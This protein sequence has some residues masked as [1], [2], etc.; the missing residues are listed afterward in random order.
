VH[1]LL[2]LALL[3]SSS[4]LAAEQVKPPPPE[5]REIPI[6][7][8]DPTPT[9]LIVAW[10]PAVFSLRVDTGKGGQFGSD[11]FEPLRGLARY[12]FQLAENKPYFGRVEVEGGRFETDDQSGLG[13]SGA[14]VTARLLAGAATRI[15]SGVIVIASAGLLTRYQWGRAQGGAPT[16]G[17]W[18]VV[19]NIELDVRVFP[20]VTLSAFVEGAIAPFPYV[21]QSNLGDLSDADE[22]RAR[23]QVS[24]DL[25]R[26]T[27]VEVGYDFTRWHAS[28]S[29]S[30]ILPNNP[31]GALLIETREHAATIGLRF[32]L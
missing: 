18:G 11:N 14:D 13:A 3:G 21:A 17:N 30:T 7:V 22:V 23:L 26:S 9:G 6:E 1:R 8:P 16:I 5:V 27:A 24:I 29:N 12:T 32:K 19:T 4:A 20:T 10:K 31:G 28:F 15:T 25:N 2:V